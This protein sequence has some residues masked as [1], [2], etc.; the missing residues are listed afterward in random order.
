MTGITGRASIVNAGSI[1]QNL[2]TVSGK[3]GERRDAFRWLKRYK[4]LPSSLAGSPVKPCVGV[5]GGST[6]AA[7]QFVYRL[8]LNVK[9]HTIR[10]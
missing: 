7:A 2:R 9:Q 3:Y 10:P 4:K 1:E 8:T 6:S 5:S